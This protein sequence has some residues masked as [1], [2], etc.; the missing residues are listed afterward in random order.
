LQKVA[1]DHFATARIDVLKG[2]AE[3]QVGVF[4]SLDARLG[5]DNFEVRSATPNDFDVSFEGYIFFPLAEG[6]PSPYST[7]DF[8]N[9]IINADRGWMP[10]SMH[11]EVRHL[12][13]GDFGRQ[14]PFAAY[15]GIGSVDQET[16]KAE[17]EAVK[18]HRKTLR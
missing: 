13:I 18:N 16:R 14:V 1:G 11:H 3:F 8:T 6:V 5:E 7:G 2:D 9:I 12:L 10:S 17:K 15:H 4:L